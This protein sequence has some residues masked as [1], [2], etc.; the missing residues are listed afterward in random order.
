MRDRKASKMSG[1]GQKKT[2]YGGVEG[3]GTGSN[4]IILD[5]AGK[6]VARSEGFSTNQWLVGMLNDFIFVIRI[7]LFQQLIHR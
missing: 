7:L 4:L 3:G 1:E 5:E 6:V 2:Y